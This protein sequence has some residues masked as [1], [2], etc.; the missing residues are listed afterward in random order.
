M[1]RLFW[2][3][4]FLSGCGVWAQ[5]PLFMEAGTHPGG[6][7]LYSRLVLFDDV[8]AWKNAWGV[9]PNFAVLPDVRI[10]EAGITGA[11]LRVKQRIYRADT[12]PVDT[13]RIS[14]QGGV[15]WREGRDPGPR[16]GLVS[17]TIRGR[18][19]VNAQVDLNA[20]EA[21]ARRYAVNASHLYRIH[22]VRYTPQTEGAWYTMLESLNDVSSDG[23]VTALAGMGLLYEARRWAA[24]AGIQAGDGDIRFAAGFRL[25]W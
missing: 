18:H 4:F 1:K 12:G 10:A 6:Q 2:L 17:T 13:W 8:L 25:L 23:D 22:P 21:S 16:V 20:G 3:G 5:E 11:D 24:E 9:T 7:Q 15:S 14:A 19:G